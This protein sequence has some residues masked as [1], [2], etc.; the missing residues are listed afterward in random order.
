LDLTLRTFPM[1]PP[2]RDKAQ[3]AL[4]AK[5]Q[6][7]APDIRWAVEVPLPILGDRR[8][9]DLVG[10]APNGSVGAELESRLVD[11]QAVARRA[12][13]KQ[14]DAGLEAML[15]VLP[16][17]RHNRSTIAAAGAAVAASF[18]LRSRAIMTPLRQGR[19]PAANGVL[20]L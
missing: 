14:R 10:R 4:L 17:T 3:L 16:D 1:G 6:T 20:F 18:P 19:I 11:W 8:A 13:L 7:A 12:L 9:I 5:L 15:I 2:V